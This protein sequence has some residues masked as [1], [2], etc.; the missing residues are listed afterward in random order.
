MVAASLVNSPSG[1]CVESVV[2]FATQRFFGEDI[3]RLLGLRWFTACK[4]D[5]FSANPGF[6]VGCF[7]GG[8]TD[9]GMTCT[10][11]GVEQGL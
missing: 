3:I 11:L 4:R 5:V 2:T 1:G 6:L 10:D 9:E 7:F 8:L